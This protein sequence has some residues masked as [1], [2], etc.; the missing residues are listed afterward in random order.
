MGV[1]LFLLN[2]KQVLLSQNDL[3]QFHVVAE[4]LGSMFPSLLRSNEVKATCFCNGKDLSFNRKYT[5]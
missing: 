5:T 3:L 2:I 1:C 4:Q